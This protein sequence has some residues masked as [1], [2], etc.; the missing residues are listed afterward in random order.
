MICAALALYIADKDGAFRS[1]R[2]TP[3]HQHANR[4]F[5]RSFRRKAC[6]CCWRDQHGCWRRG[7]V[8]YLGRW[9]V[10]SVRAYWSAAWDCIRFSIILSVHD[11]HV[12]SGAS[13]EWGD[14]FTLHR[15]CL[16][17]RSDRV[18]RVA[19]NGTATPAWSAVLTTLAGTAIAGY[20]DGTGSAALFNA[21]SGV[22]MNYAGTTA[23]VVSRELKN[24][25]PSCWSAILLTGPPLHR[26]FL[27]RWITQMPASVKSYC[28]QDRY[29]TIVGGST[30]YSDG[31]ASAVAFQLAHTTSGIAMDAGGTFALC[32]EYAVCA[33]RLQVYRVLSLPSGGYFQSGYSLHRHL[34]RALRHLRGHLL[35]LE[36]MMGMVHPQSLRAR[37]LF[38]WILR[39]PSL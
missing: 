34:K 3:G 28:H 10:G 4:V 22:S 39:G 38:Q 12:R 26:R 30:G 21:P 36:V 37:S 35:P 33:L 2:N 24:A 8:R 25:P 32:C 13:E 14:A 7:R 9:D 27:V 23:V 11:G 16:N 31:I 29:L 19:R 15:C 18:I 1:R 6:Q 17:P 5:R 20:A